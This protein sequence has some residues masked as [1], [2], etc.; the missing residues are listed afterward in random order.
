MVDLDVKHISLHHFQKH[1]SKCIIFIF[2][3]LFKTSRLPA[4][5]IFKLSQLLDNKI[6][7]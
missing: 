1:I 5:N 2:D 3:R 4:I 7:Y 6:Y